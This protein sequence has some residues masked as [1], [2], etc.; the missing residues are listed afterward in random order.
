MEE[1][2]PKPLLEKSHRC[3]HTP[4][5]CT[6]RGTWCTP[7]LRKAL[8]MGYR[9][10]KIHEVWHFRK[11]Q[12]GLFA[13]YVNTWLK[14][15][16]E[17]AGYPAWCNTPG[18]KAHYVSQYRQ[19]EGIALDPDMIQ[20]NPGRKATAKLM[21]NSFWGKFRENLHKPTTQSVY[22][23]A[24][25]FAV[26][27]DPLHDIRQVR[28]VNDKTLEVVYTNHKDNQPDNGRV[29]IFVAA[30]TTCWALLKLYSY[31]EQLQ[32]RVLYFDMDSV[33]YTTKPDDSDIPLGDYLGEMT[34]E[35]D[36][37]DS[38]T[39]FTSAG[40]KNYGYKTQ[41]GKV[42][43]KVRGFSLNVRGSRQLN[44]DVMRQNLHDEILDPLDE[45]RNIPV[46]NPNFFYRN[47]ATKQ[48]K[49]APHTKRYGLV[50]D[51]RV[52]DKNTFKSY[53]Y[54]YTQVLHDDEDM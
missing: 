14:I 9:L 48:L 36:D 11:R 19:K 4:E 22:T 23:A 42:C 6:L 8:E 25:L 1:E 18:D 2:M 10:L 17:S 30:F 46:V 53:P 16:Q 26:V 38:I 44:Y 37:G 39:E 45:R 40:P 24:A 21:L 31:L 49:V 20:K 47:P 50:F 51:K 7:E 52:V 41:Q 15:K 32:Q 33:I 34:N 28:I 5:Q 43:C 3:S 35:L 27:S 54:G 13:D 12:K 29:N